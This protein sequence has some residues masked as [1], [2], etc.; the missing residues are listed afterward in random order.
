MQF[1]LDT[2]YTP[3]EQEFIRRY[4]CRVL[5]EITLRRVA[6]GE[7]EIPRRMLVY[8][9]TTL[10]EIFDEGEWGWAVLGKDRKGQWA[11]TGGVYSDLPSMAEGL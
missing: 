10:G 4:H 6:F 7:E 11:W 2:H 5:R 3:E 8:C 9:G 1:A